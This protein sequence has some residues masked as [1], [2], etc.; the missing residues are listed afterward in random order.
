MS[1]PARIRIRST[2]AWE[3]ILSPVR[4]EIV[5][6]M[7]ALGPCAIAD[8]ARATGRPADGLYRHVRILLKSGFLVEAGTRTAS[9]NVERLYDAAA[10]DFAAPHVKRRAAASEREMIVRT[11]EVLAKST[12]RT[13]RNSAEAGRIHCDADSRNFSVM[14]MNCWLTPEQFEELRSIVIR[15]GRVLEQGRAQREGDLYEVFTVVAPVTRQRG[16]HSMPRKGRGR[17]NSR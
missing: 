14:H 7:Q 13:L 5:E 2:Q 4:R 15:M 16:T 10:N 3:A 8:V 6:S 17:E 11:A 9:R 12:V 1:R